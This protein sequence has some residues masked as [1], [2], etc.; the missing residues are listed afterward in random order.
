MKKSVIAVIAAQAAAAVFFTACGSQAKPA[1]TTKA[2]ETTAAV[3]TTAAAET[4]AAPETTAAETAAAETTAAETAEAAQ[5]APASL[6]EF[7]YTDGS[8]YLNPIL[9]YMKKNYAKHYDPAD[10]LIPAFDFLREDET[11]PEDIKVWGRFWINNYSLRG[12]TL[13]HR[14]G[15]AYDGCAHLKKTDGGYE[16][17]SI[18][19]V[20]DGSDSGPSTERIFG[21][22]KEL[23]EGYRA[24]DADFNDC[25]AS[26]VHMYSE[27]TGVEI[28]AWSDYGW[29]PV[30]L[31]DAAEF[32]VSY[33]DLK[34]EWKAENG[35]EAMTVKNPEDGNIYEVEVKTEKD[36]KDAKRRFYGQYEQSTNSL[37]YWDGWMISG[38]NED[39]F[40]GG[41]IF[42][43]TEEGNLHWTADDGTDTVFVRQ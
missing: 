43:I 3:E 42:K 8:P 11:N 25:M 35:T 37:Y 38:E 9:D 2:A 1:E 10:V 26:A 13:M 34:G 18:D 12:T 39:E 24:S 22:D 29:D 31:P 33:P 23:M 21:I 17:T 16:V 20:Q 15:G 40:S 14:N 7:V 36:G 6:P 4:T 5:A 19:M 32:E 28:K 41:G 30:P 27:N